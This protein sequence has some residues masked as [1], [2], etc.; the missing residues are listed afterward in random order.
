MGVCSSKTRVSH[1]IIS[2][3]LSCWPGSVLD[4]SEEDL[5]DFASCFSLYKVKEGKEVSHDIFTLIISCFLL[6]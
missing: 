2:D 6:V 1:N 4:W 5:H 3:L